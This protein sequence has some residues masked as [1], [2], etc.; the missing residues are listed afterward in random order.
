MKLSKHK[1]GHYGSR[2][3]K[4]T[5]ITRAAGRGTGAGR[6]FRAC[7][8]RSAGGGVAEQ[9]RNG[10]EFPA[11]R[12]AEQGGPEA[13]NKPELMLSCDCFGSSSAPSHRGRYGFLF[14]VLEL[15]RGDLCAES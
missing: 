8:A 7:A 14:E 4:V 11:E 15:A 5:S 3:I 1:N 2:K 9:A 12:P 6:P 10:A 13:R